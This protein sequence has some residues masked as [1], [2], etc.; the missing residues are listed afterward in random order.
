[1]TLPNPLKPGERVAVGMSGGVDSTVAA[2]F[3]KRQGVDVFGLTM[4][5]WAGPAGQP[6]AE[7]GCHGCYGPGEAEDIEQARAIAERLGIPHHTVDLTEPYAREVIGPFRG[8]YGRGRTPNPCVICNSRMKFGFLLDKAREQGLAFDAFAT[9]HYA[10]IRFD[11]VRCR[12]GL[13]KA[14]DPKKDQSYFLARLTQDQL[15]RTLFPLGE[16]TKPEVKRWAA[17]LG[18]ADVADKPESQDFVD[19]GDYTALFEGCALSPGPIQDEAGHVL[20]QHRG[21]PYYTIG[22]RKGLGLSGTAD[23]LFVIRID[24]ERNAL[25]VGPKAALY[26]DRLTAQQVNWI[27]VDRLEAPC[28]A[29]V[30]IRQQHAEAAAELRP[31]SPF[32]PSRVDVIFD[33]PQMSIA[34]GQTVVFYEDDSV[35]GGGVIA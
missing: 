4:R 6:A 20:G 27:A 23:P 32:D 25:V 21:L 1:M 3:L 15:S 29:R 5:I 28:R 30:K 35:L 24:A 31:V 8:E 13:L 16:L 10:R 33:Q 12:Y 34:P 18:F 2:A 19:G 22:Q 7:K 9:G 11:E 17:E 14:V 26:S